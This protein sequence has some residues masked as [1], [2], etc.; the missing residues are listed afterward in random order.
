MGDKAAVRADFENADTSTLGIRVTKGLDIRHDGV[1]LALPAREIVTIFLP[2]HVSVGSQDYPLPA[3]P[4]GDRIVPAI[5]E[6]TL[7]GFRMTLLGG[8][9]LLSS[10]QYITD[11]YLGRVFPFI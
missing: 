6:I 8:L 1:S 2:N 4:K 7:C 9:T 10:L 5:D 3:K 11:N